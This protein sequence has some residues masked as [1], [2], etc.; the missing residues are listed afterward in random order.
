ML[1]AAKQKPIDRLRVKISKSKFPKK[2]QLNSC[3]LITDVPKFIRAHFMYLDNN[4]GKGKPDWINGTV[5][6]PY[7]ERLQTLLKHANN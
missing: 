4:P 5:F 3:E 1:R 7:Y 6:M 2:I